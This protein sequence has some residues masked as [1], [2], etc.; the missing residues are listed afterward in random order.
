MVIGYHDTLL[1]S[2]ELTGLASLY[3]KLLESQNYKVITVS[4]N[5]L[6]PHHKNIERVKMIQQKLRRSFGIDD[7]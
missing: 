1:G 2:T 7:V 3:I 6:K 5:E 4:H